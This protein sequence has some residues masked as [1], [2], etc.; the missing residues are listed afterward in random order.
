MIIFVFLF[1]LIKIEVEKGEGR[2]LVLKKKVQRN[3]D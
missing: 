3:W 1:N 2:E